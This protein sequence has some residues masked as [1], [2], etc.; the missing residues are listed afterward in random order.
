MNNTNTKVEYTKVEEVKGLYT[1]IYL[2]KSL[3]NAINQSVWARFNK[4]TPQLMFNSIQN[5][6]KVYFEKFTLSGV[7]ILRNAKKVPDPT[8]ESGERTE[9]TFYILTSDIKDGMLTTEPVTDLDVDAF[10][11]TE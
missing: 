7:E 10:T 2:L 8:A 1:K 6:K 9:T 4:Q 3:F 5:A 11:S